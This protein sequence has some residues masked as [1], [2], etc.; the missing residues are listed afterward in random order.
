M[1]KLFDSYTIFARIFPSIISSLP[2]LLLWY[3][4][5]ENVQL[6][7]L[8]S[9][10]LSIKFFGAISI[11]V[12]FLYF[13]AQ[14]IRITSK[15]FENK[16][17]IKNKGFPTTYLMTYE[18]DAYS[19]VYKDQYREFVRKNFNLELL[20]KNEEK[21]NIIEARKRLNETTKLII[22][23]IRDG[24]LVKKHNIWYGFFRNLIGGSIYS[25][26]FCL[27]NV[28]VSHFLLKNLTLTIF[29][30]VLL[31]MYLVVFLFRNTIL[32]QN[33]EA[34]AKQIISEFFSIN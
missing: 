6:T 30:I 15:Y 12:I 24:V 3:S 20:S 25:I 5:S 32:K 9:F 19:E 21:S 11:T 7:K 17:F 27:L 28:F 29:S 16:Y 22:L 33:A 13:Y 1:A 34:Y 18:N 8:I 26:I 23:K 31:T 10:L 2:L 14:L 4:L